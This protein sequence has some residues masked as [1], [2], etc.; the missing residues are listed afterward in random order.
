MIPS[1]IFRNISF[2]YCCL[3]YWKAILTLLLCVL[4]CYYCS[5]GAAAL[6]EEEIPAEIT[7]ETFVSDILGLPIAEP[8]KKNRRKKNNL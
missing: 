5:P 2:T 7:A 3:L 8:E 1:Y 6:T 4:C